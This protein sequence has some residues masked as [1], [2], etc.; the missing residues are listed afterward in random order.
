MKYIAHLIAVGDWLAVNDIFELKEISPYKKA[1]VIHGIAVTGSA[2]LGDTG[3]ELKQG[4]E[5]MGRGFNSKIGNAATAAVE[6]FP[7]QYQKL[8]AYRKGEEWSLFPIAD[9]TT[10]GVYLHLWMTE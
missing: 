6:D 3:Y 10:N 9:A 7:K 2:V 8:E 4:E 5:I 1:A